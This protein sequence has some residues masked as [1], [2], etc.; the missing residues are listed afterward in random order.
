M[1]DLF[2]ARAIRYIT[3]LIRD[4]QLED[5]QAA[6][7]P[8]NFGVE[9]GGFVHVQ[10]INPVGGGQ[11]GLGDAQWTG[12]RRREFEA[13]LARRAEMNKSSDPRDYDANYS[14]LFREL[15]GGEGRRVLPKLRLAANVDQA[16]EIV[17]NEY[18]RPGEPHL[19]RRKEYGRQALAAFRAAG[20][21]VAALKASSRSAAGVT[22]LPPVATLPPLQTNLNLET[23]LPLVL[24][25]LTM[26]QKQQTETTGKTPD[27]MELLTKILQGGL[28]P[29]VPAPV[30]VVVAPAPAKTVIPPS[31]GLGLTGVLGSLAAMATNP[32]LLGTPLGMG[33]NPTVAGNIVPLIFAAIPFVASFFGPVGSAIGRVVS[34]AG[35]ALLNRTS[36]K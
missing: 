27:V 28:T 3:D 11:G 8:G 10:E 20:I 17:M 19:E 21:D 12:P 34:V 14:M 25:V 16:T 2:E 4:F 18:E 26:L 32:P 6:G 24:G 23:L 15:D 30:P 22:I 1:S 31:V 35:P 9:T 5:F 13:W 7:F 36:P 29:P 33:E